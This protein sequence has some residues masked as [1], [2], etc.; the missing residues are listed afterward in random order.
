ML[1]RD[2]LAILSLESGERWIDAAHDFQREDAFAVLEGEE[3]YSFLTRSR[4][5][6][7]TTDLAAVALS[8]LVAADH[9]LRAY[10]LAADADQGRLAVDAIAG[11]VSRTPSLAGRVDVQNRRVLVPESGA[12]LEVLPADAPSAWGLTPH[13]LLCDELANW[14][15]GPSARR[16]WEAASS[17][18]AKRSDARMVVLTTAGS[19][20]HFAFRILEH[21]RRSPLWRT[22]ERD[23]PGAVDG[24]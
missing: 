19:P 7:K 20:D 8:V 2:V 1:A 9:R 23:G 6:S 16:L 24:G 12:V 17:A 5:S 11:F 21:A 13:L 4:G 3:P 14:N 18:V 22:S 15:D 10:W